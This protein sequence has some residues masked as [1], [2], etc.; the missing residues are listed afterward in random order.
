[1]S[2]RRLKTVTLVL[3]GEE[4]IALLDFTN[5]DEFSGPRKT[6]LSKIFRILIR[7]DTEL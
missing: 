1:M 5:V 7:L 2:P 4:A 6:L 3:S